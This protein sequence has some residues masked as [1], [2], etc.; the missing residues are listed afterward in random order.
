MAATKMVRNMEIFKEV[1]VMATH[2][3]AGSTNQL[4]RS[5]RQP[6]LFLPL[7]CKL[8][9]VLPESK[10]ISRML[11]LFFMAIVTAKVEICCCTVPLILSVFSVHLVRFL[12]K[13]DKT[14]CRA[15][16][17]C[18]VLEQVNPRRSFIVAAAYK[19]PVL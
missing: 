16:P 19:C 10:A 1:W 9:P 6:S 11:D 12:Q 5:K 7:N 2:K 3:T 17:D 13:S 15:K 8:A 18:I 4:I 14:N